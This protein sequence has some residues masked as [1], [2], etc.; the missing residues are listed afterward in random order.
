MAFSRG[1]FIGLLVASVL[2]VPVGFSAAAPAAPGRDAASRLQDAIDGL[3]DEPN[4][5]PGAVVVVQRGSGREVF[6]AGVADIDRTAPPG[7]DL[8]MRIA[9]TAKA[10]SGGVA[11]ALVD[12]G[13]LALDDTI[14]DRL[15]WAPAAWSAVTL[16]QALHHTSGLPD[17]TMDRQFGE[18]LTAHLTRPLPPRR[19]LRFVTDKP[20]RFAPGTDFHYSNTDNIVVALMTQ[21]ATGRR[22]DQLLDRRVLSPL[23]LYRTSLPQGVRLSSPSLHGYE[24]EADGALTD[25][26]R[27]MAAGYAWASGGI[28]GTPSDQNRFI[29]GYVGHKLFT[30]RT[31]EAQFQWRRGAHSEPPGPGVNAAGLGVFR[32]RTGCGTV[33]GHTGNIFGYT[34]FLAASANGRR[35]VVV[36]INSQATPATAPIVFRHLRDVFR[37]AVCTALA[38]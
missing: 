20:L 21:S 8:F 1:G 24:H 38:D 19:L 4:G 16:K 3:V 7:P 33:F 27:L 28:V 30:R 35:S 5:P 15:P 31:Q 14:G 10:Y 25:V 32:Y 17:Y 12:D 2:A 11:L 6:R 34:Q 22:Y 26:S 37:L 18:H 13:V 36:S 29:R 23:G 9:S